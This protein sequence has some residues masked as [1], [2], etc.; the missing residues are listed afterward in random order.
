MEIQNQ[1]EFNANRIELK[2]WAAW[3]D[4]VTLK[5]VCTGKLPS[6]SCS[7]G[8]SSSTDTE[9]SP[10]PSLPPESV[11]VPGPV[12]GPEPP[13]QISSSI[14]DIK[15][16]NWTK[17]TYPR[18]MKLVTFIFS[19]NE[20]IITGDDPNLNV[21][22]NCNNENATYVHGG[23]VVKI[24]ANISY[25]YNVNVSL[26]VEVIDFDTYINLL[27]AKEITLQELTS[28]YTGGPVKATLWSQRQPIRA[29]EASLFVASIYNDGGGVID[30]INNFIVKIPKKL[31]TVEI[32]SST[33]YLGTIGAENC[34]KR[35]SGGDF[36]EIYCQNYV[37]SRKIKTGEYKRVSF[38]ITPASEMDVDR[39]TRLIIGLANYDY[40]KTTSKSIIVANTPYH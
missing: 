36:I 23:Q 35:D 4:P 12:P 39:M 21:C 10:L 14:C 8:G 20:W 30:K 16:C 38:L 32:V 28:Q 18:E 13:S 3:K 7:S 26:P 19:K 17:V 2:V 6:F 29:G 24:N 9:S 25:T 31:G 22:T 15:T 5:E 11:P 37:S 40:T 27:Q 34:E 1:G 33:F